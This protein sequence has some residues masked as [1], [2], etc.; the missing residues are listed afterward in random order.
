M[1]LQDRLIRLANMVGAQWDRLKGKV[2]AG[3]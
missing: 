2:P 3:Y 1:N